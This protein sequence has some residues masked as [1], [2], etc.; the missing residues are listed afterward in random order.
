MIPCILRT[1]Q[2]TALLKYF[3]TAAPN[4]PKSAGVIEASP[5]SA[6]CLGPSV[7]SQSKTTIVDSEAVTPSDTSIPNAYRLPRSAR[8][9]TQSR[10]APVSVSP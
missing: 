2:T 4:R 6:T 1:Q 10:P 5:I 8:A 7:W 9:Y 3:A